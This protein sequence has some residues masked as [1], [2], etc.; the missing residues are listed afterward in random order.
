MKEELTMVRQGLKQDARRRVTEALSARQKR[1][2]ERERR[3]ASLA[4]GIL[5]ALAERDEA[6]QI[7]EKQAA[8][9]VRALLAERLNVSRKKVRLAE[10]SIRE[11][12]VRFMLRRRGTRELGHAE[13]A[14]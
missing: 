3:Q 10:E 7:A 4:V 2:V 1:R 5:S 6:I 13:G 11:R 12:L 9:A 14:R 8:Q